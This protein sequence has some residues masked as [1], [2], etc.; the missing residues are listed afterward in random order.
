[1]VQV[2]QHLGKALSSNPSTTTKKKKK[3]QEMP[4]ETIFYR[5]S[6]PEGFLSHDFSTM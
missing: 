6:L 2:V 4:L 1:M 5:L 3:K